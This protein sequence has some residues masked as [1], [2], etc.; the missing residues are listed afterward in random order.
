MYQPKAFKQD[1][2]ESMHELIRRHSLATLVTLTAG[3]IEANHVPL[4]IDPSPA[5]FGTLTGHVARANPLWRE[6]DRGV[7]VLA[8]FSA[9]QGYITPSWYATKR[10]TGKVVPTWNYAVVHGYG[11]LVIHDDREWLR[12]FLTRLTRHNEAARA[13]PW[14][15]TDAPA[16]Y[17]DMRLA[18]I[19]GIEIPLTRLEGKWKMSQNRV[20][21][22]RAGVIE[23]LR[24]EGGEQ[25]AAM[26]ELVESV[27]ARKRQP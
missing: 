11:P 8:V 4:L 27:N 26:A 23:G 5:P 2:V 9:V 6:S 21:R 22:D 14:E 7:E 25:S 15:V 10:E 17:V 24:A 13:E 19:V 3:A 1:S 18:E 16:D 20:P 12:A